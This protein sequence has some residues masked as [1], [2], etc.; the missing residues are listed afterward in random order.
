MSNLEQCIFPV[1]CLAG[2]LVFMHVK[3]LNEVRI[4]R[5]TENTKLRVIP[6]FYLF[7]CFH[8]CFAIFFL[9][10]VLQFLLNC[11]RNFVSFICLLVYILHHG[12]WFM[13]TIFGYISISKASTVVFLG[14]CFQLLAK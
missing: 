10:T 5:E 9:Y 4:S 1:H 11:I 8:Y 3:S 7:F 6:V 2:K 14:L 12:T 13:R